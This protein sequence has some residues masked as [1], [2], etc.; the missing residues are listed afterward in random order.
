MQ[1]INRSHSRKKVAIIISVVAAVLIVAGGVS[2]FYLSRTSPQNNQSDKSTPNNTIDY[3]AATTDQKK[4]GEDAKKDFL[5]RTES[6][7]KT[8]TPTQPS[9][10]SSVSISSI[11]QEGAIV[12][13]RT[14]VS[15]QTAGNCKLTLSMPGQAD[16]VR[17][18]DTQDMGSYSTCKGFDVD[19]STMTKGTWKA[20][21]YFSGD[22][23]GVV[24]TDIVEVR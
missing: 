16:V 20:T 1:E 18:A 8:D 14:V 12:K 2:A 24:S 23:S 15:A 5:E 9:S 3:G 10:S 22:A 7:T 21:L 19:T 4:A 17:T 11:N 6:E 13:I